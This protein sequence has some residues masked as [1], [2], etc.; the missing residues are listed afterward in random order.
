M[1]SFF[2]RVGQGIGLGLGAGLVV[3]IYAFLNSLWMSHRY[4][5]YDVATINKPSTPDLVS[6]RGDLLADPSVT[7][8]EVMEQVAGDWWGITWD[9]NSDLLYSF[10]WHGATD[11]TDVIDFHY[12]N[13]DAS[14][15]FTQE[16]GLWWIKRLY[17][18][19]MTEDFDETYR[20]LHLSADHM[21][22]QSVVRSGRAVE[23]GR[24]YVKSRSKALLKQI[25]ATLTPTEPVEE[26]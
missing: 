12:V 17:Y 14:S 15:W 2:Q 25:E 23:D 21:V 13:D 19:H 7:D 20:I 5:D 22:Y 10:S 1:K 11:G 9:P 3:A 24:I 16:R 4:G 18:H 8:Q 26:P 6:D